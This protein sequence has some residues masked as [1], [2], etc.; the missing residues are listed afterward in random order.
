MSFCGGGDVG[1]SCVLGSYSVSWLTGCL[2]EILHSCSHVAGTGW[3]LRENAELPRGTQKG[4][5]NEIVS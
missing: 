3:R 1:I 5:S 2:L 4:D